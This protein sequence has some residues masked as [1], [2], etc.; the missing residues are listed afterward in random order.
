LTGTATA[1]AAAPA[2]TTTASDLA[3]IAQAN[4]AIVRGARWF[5]WVAGLSLVNTV[6]SHS[7]SQINFVIGLGFTLVVDALLK[8]LILVALVID[9]LAIGFSFG[10]GWFAGKG[11]FWAFVV[12]AIAYAGDLGLCLLGQDWMMIG[13]HGLALFY[14]GRGAL[15]LRADIKAAKQTA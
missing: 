14:I 2:A 6:L 4:P 1:T 10:V 13:F 12:G 9:A 7:G 3:A 11:R 15:A 8:N 5:W